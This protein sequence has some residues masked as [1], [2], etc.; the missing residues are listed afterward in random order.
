MKH[1]TN[2]KMFHRVV[3]TAVVVHQSA[4]NEINQN[5]GTLWIRIAMRS[6]M[7]ALCDVKDIPMSK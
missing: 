7:I 5:F 6:R 2:T 1:F 3:I 4:V